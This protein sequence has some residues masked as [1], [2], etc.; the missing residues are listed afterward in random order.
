M[1]ILT[2]LQKKVV[3]EYSKTLDHLSDD[4]QRTLIK[5]DLGNTA[6][7]NSK[8]IHSGFDYVTDIYLK[9]LYY[10]KDDF[11]Q[12]TEYEGENIQN[13]IEI[14]ENLVKECNSKWVKNKFYR[15]IN[16]KY[17]NTLMTKWRVLIN[18][19]DDIQKQLTYLKEFTDD[20]EYKD[21]NYFEIYAKLDLYSIIDQDFT[22]LIKE[23]KKDS[24]GH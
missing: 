6:M 4:T 5:A 21:L 13:E 2:K 1:N 11:N 12:E 15:K 20:G 7:K 23:I 3:N 10:L 14:I 19:K 9:I 22:F 18:I 16:P 8:L 17:I 24:D